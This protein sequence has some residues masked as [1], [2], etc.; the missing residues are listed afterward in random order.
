VLDGKTIKAHKAI[1][2]ARSSYFEAMFRSFSPEND[3]VNVSIG[4]MVPSPKSFDSLLRYIYFGDVTM[5]PEDS[6]YL[7]SAP[8]YYGFTNNRLQAYCK[9][10]LEMN[11]SVK[12][13]IQILEAAHSI[14]A[15]DMER[16]ALSIIVQH[17]PKVARLQ[18]FRRLKKELLL[19]I[20]D[21][22]AEY[23]QSGSN[24]DYVSFQQ[25]VDSI[26]IGDQRDAR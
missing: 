1:L 26:D 17:F 6:L 18:D 11:V 21:A 23:M 14:D 24:I 8:F 25:Q 12:N 2:A 13:V 9:Q 3:R 7:F 20:L 4:E 10:N 19:D 5:A 22:I 16:H 15:I